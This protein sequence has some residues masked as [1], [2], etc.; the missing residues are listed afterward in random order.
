[1]EDLNYEGRRNREYQIW[2]VE[3]KAQTVEWIWESSFVNW[4]SEAGGLFWICGKPASG[5][6]TLM[7]S[8]A[9]STELA[10]RLRCTFDGECIIIRHF[11]DFRAGKGIGN[12]FEGLLRSL[13]YQ[14]VDD[15]RNH[16]DVNLDGVD[17]PKSE[18]KQ[19]W[20]IRALK[21]AMNTVLRQHSH[22]ICILLDG[23]DEYEGD[24]WSLASFVRELANPRVKICI[25][26]RPDPVF[27]FSFK[28]LATIKMEEQNT[29]AINTM[30]H[31]TIKDMVEPDF[32]DSSAAVELVRRISESANG[33]FLWARFAIKEV[34]D[35]LSKGRGLA[36]LYRKLDNVPQELEK[37]YGR[38]LEQLKPQDRQK[39]T[40]MLQLVCY[41]QR[42]LTLGELCVATTQAASEQGLVVEQMSEVEIQRFEKKVLALTGGVLEIFSSLDEARARE[43]SW[44][45]DSE[46]LSQGSL[47]LHET[48][49][50]EGQEIDGSEPRGSPKSDEAESYKIQDLHVSVIHRTFRTYMDSSGWSLLLNARHEGMLHAHVLWLRVCTGVFR[51]SFKGLPPDE[52]GSEMTQKRI[53]ATLTGS[54]PVHSNTQLSSRRT[55]GPWPALGET[56]DS[57]L[58]VYAACNML[59]HALR[60][61][62]DLGLRYYELLQS[63][64]SN[65]FLCYHR[66]YTRGACACYAIYSETL[67]PLHVAIVHGLVEY[68]KAYLS[69]I[70]D[71][72]SRE[73]DQVS[74]LEVA[75]ELPQDGVGTTHMSLLE[76]T[77][78]HAGEC[79]ILEFS[80]DWEPLVAEILDHYPRVDDA[81]ILFAL[82]SC[83]P[84]VVHLLLSHLPSGKMALKEGIWGNRVY[85]KDDLENELLDYIQKPFDVGP[86]W[87]V[88]IRQDYLVLEDA[89]ELIDVFLGRGEDIN[90]QCGPFGT[91]LH[92]ALFCL[93]RYTLNLRMWEL[94]VSKGADVNAVGVFGTPLEFVWRLLYRSKKV[95][96]YQLEHY[97]TAIGWLIRE[98]ATNNQPDPNGSIPTRERMLD[99]A[100]VGTTDFRD[101]QRLY[102]GTSVHEESGEEDE[103]DGYEE[104][105]EADEADGPDEPV[106]E[107][108][109][110]EEGKE[111]ED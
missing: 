41:A 49:L 104:Y 67:H 27:S 6:S 94:L 10:D 66:Y 52:R 86:L 78:R 51:A 82:K 56:M 68:V 53:R 61:E 31:E 21:E 58:L 96:D 22:P 92:G 65:S 101:F 103:Y 110:D 37:I 42:T 36:Y 1:M 59:T 79:V 3:A 57:P 26:S 102:R 19:Q 63:G 44:E 109:E 34:R 90:E 13:L 11:F 20:S 40:H 72:G 50:H 35:G 98:G 106:E 29:P 55:L 89:V 71:Q 7:D 24:K 14:L 25:A 54:S 16:K 39:T 91:A 23:L 45:T 62:Q 5:K 28:D 85:Q 108:A 2:D 74:Y 69:T 12:N 95:S 15:S 30:V 48:D 84:K 87:Y 70:G 111:A 47:E 38:I 99:F 8:I 100:E 76:F 83:S 107:D 81:A 9:R 75:R 80:C 32:Y 18:S 46:I 33:V 77:V 4:T 73:W 43:E 60:I 105:D 88:A 17:L 64:M 93:G 97:Q